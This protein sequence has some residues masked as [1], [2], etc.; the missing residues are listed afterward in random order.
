MSDTLPIVR[1]SERGAL[2]RCPQSWYWAYRMGLTAPDGMVPDYFWFGIGIHEALAQWYKKGLRRGQHP[3]RFFDKWAGE[4]I[5]YIKTYLD[6]EDKEWYDQVKYEDAHDLG[7]RMLEEY[8]EFYGKDPTWDVIATEQ[9]FKVK[10]K[11]ADTPI[12]YFASRWD[13][14]YRDLEDGQVYLGEHKTAGSI[15]LAYLALDDQAGAYCAVANSLLR[16]NGTL[17][18]NERIAGITYNFLRKAPADDRP[19]NEQGE[20]LNNP[21]KEHFVAALTGIDGWTVPQ[22][23]KMTVDELDSVAAANHVLVQGEVSKRQPPPKF[24]REIVDRTPAQ[25][26]TQME[27]LAAEV[28]IMNGMRDGTIPIIKHTSKDCVRC[29]FFEMCQLHERGGT[30][31]QTMARSVFRRQDPYADMRKSAAE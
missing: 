4:E 7:I 31:W 24:V 6:E 20:Y 23:K 17:G 21:T 19:Q 27:R 14:V 1:T 26:R 11:A 3:A 2:R 30:A 15:S 25:N 16:A 18:P 13:L 8:I 28:Q 22:L 29:V 9:G 12:A 10:I 5:R